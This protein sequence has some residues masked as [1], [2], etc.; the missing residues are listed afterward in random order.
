MRVCSWPKCR[1]FD[2]TRPRVILHSFPLRA[3]R[4]WAEIS[5]CPKLMRVNV[6]VLNKHFWLCSKHFTPEMYATR[7]SLKTGALPSHW[8]S[9]PPLEGERDQRGCRRCSEAIVAA[10]GSAPRT[11][12]ERMLAQIRYHEKRIIEIQSKLKIL[13]D[14]EESE[15]H[16]GSGDS[17]ESASNNNVKDRPS[18]TDQED[19]GRL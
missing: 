3:A 16:G 8:T 7:K 1:S 10:K 12:R 15:L 2:G 11:E 13:S 9:Q 18:D 17:G 14:K 6:E 5:G 4:R 19:L